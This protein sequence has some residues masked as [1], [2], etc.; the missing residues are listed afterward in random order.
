MKKT[1]SNRNTKEHATA[2]ADTRL[3]RSA[4]PLL[5]GV[6][7]PLALG[8]LSACGGGGGSSTALPLN[9]NPAP[10]ND[11]TPPMTPAGGSNFISGS[12]LD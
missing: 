2:S 9:P 6:V 7:V 12:F 4:R 10:A 3:L 8:L 5:G 1:S 11:Q